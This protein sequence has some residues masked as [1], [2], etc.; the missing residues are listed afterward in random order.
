[1]KN[2]QPYEIYGSE[3]IQENHGMMGE[4]SCMSEAAKANM[5]KICEEYLAKEAAEYHD[6]DDAEHTYEGYVAQCSKYLSECMGQ[7]GYAGLNKIYAE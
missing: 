5:K 1:M 7:A 6:D 3:D 2:L 4:S